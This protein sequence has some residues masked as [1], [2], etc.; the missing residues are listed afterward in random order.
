MGSSLDEL[1]ERLAA[2]SEA[3]SRAGSELESVT[4]ALRK[5]KLSER[6]ATGQLVTLISNL[7]DALMVEDEHRNI[8]HS[9]QAFSNLFGLPSPS[10]IVGWNCA[11]AAEESKNFFKD[12]QAF[13]VRIEQVLKDRRPAIGDELQLADGRTLIRDYIPIILDAEYRGHFWRYTEV[14]S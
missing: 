5:A 2:R 10:R 8:V 13:V 1:E 12:P 7:P 9:N 4:A 14:P 3:L 6:T 11:N